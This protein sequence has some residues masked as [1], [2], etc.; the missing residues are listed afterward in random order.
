MSIYDEVRMEKRKD[1]TFWV[2]DKRGPNVVEQGPFPSM[3]VAH[4]VWTIYVDAIL[5]DRSCVAILATSDE[6]ALAGRF[7]KPLSR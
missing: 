4:E 2:L 6:D 7:P 3:D 1:G 5:E